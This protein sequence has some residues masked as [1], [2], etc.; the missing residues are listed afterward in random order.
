MGLGGEGGSLACV[1]PT[2]RGVRRHRTKLKQQESKWPPPQDTQPRSRPIM[3]EDG[4]SDSALAAAR[5]WRL[6]RTAVDRH[7]ARCAS[8]D[9]CSGGAPRRYSPSDEQHPPVEVTQSAMLRGTREGGELQA[10]FP[11]LKYT[12]HLPAERVYNSSRPGWPDRDG[13]VSHKEIPP[14]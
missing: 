7:A 11:G 13:H 5:G 3:G 12:F 1:H 9:L 14:Q 4:P 6:R 10:T 2:K 8:R